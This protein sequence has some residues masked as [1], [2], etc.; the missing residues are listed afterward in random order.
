MTLFDHSCSEDSEVGSLKQ[1]CISFTPRRH[2][3]HAVRTTSESDTGQNI[4][5][6]NKILTTTNGY[7]ISYTKKHLIHETN[8][9]SPAYYERSFLFL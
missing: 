4:P 3:H 8:I 1:V 7:Y 2:S 6:D 5:T 9:L